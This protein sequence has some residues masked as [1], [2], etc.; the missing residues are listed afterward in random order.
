MAKLKPCPFCG[1]VNVT[2]KQDSTMVCGHRYWF[3]SHSMPSGECPLTDTWGWWHS[4]P[5]FTTK[6]KAIEAWNRRAG[7]EDK[8]D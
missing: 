2:V 3:I 5:K 4:R 6:E 1:G 7:E 8:H